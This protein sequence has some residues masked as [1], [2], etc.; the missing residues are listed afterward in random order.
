LGE[1]TNQAI[2]LRQGKTIILNLWRY[3]KSEMLE[4]FQRDNEIYLQRKHQVQTNI[5]ARAE[6]RRR[7]AEE[8]AKEEA[9][10]AREEAEQAKEE[11]AQNRQQTGS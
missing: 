4:K 10:I 6:A 8:L 9:E 3:G 11:A 5:L 2:D 1:D 7:L